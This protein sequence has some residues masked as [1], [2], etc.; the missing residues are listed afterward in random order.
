[1]AASAQADSAAMMDMP[2]CPSKAAK[3][4]SKDCGC[5]D[6]KAPCQGD[7]CLAK[8]F[9]LN[10]EIIKSAVLID[11]SEAAFLTAVPTRTPDSWPEPQKRPPRA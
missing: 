11:L 1:M 5:C 3:Q 2:D 7:L 9:K 4:A 8:C 6:A 10:G